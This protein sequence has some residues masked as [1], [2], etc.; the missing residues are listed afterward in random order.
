MKRVIMG[1]ALCVAA[2]ASLAADG[3]T[4]TVVYAVGSELSIIRDRKELKVDEPMGYVVQAGDIVQTGKNTMI[5]LL[6]KPK[7]AV[8]RVSG[9]TTFQFRGSYPTGETSLAVLYGRVRAKV[10]KLAGSERFTMRNEGTVAG[11]RGTDFGMDVVLTKDGSS[12]Q[13]KVSVYSFQGEVSV[14]SAL[15]ASSSVQ[16]SNTVKSGEMAQILVKDDTVS[17]SMGKLSDEVQN[18]WKDNAYASADAA[19]I[20]APPP[21]PAVAAAPAAAA[22]PSAAAGTPV[23]V[24]PP[25]ADA[26]KDEAPKLD[27]G[28]TKKTLAIKNGMLVSSVILVS[29][30][31]GL[32]IYA[33]YRA[34][35]VGADQTTNLMLFGGGI[36][37]ST[38][39]M[40]GLFGLL[41]N[42]NIPAH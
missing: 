38:G 3:G 2:F 29:V 20:V 11:V 37:A 32:E 21:E 6:I 34:G 23:V 8:I 7:K 33:S 18:Y 22:E 17:L 24:A 42:P 40:C 5:E 9:N 14:E 10:E 16:A 39:L 1:L 4:A 30:G 41:L 31:A 19:G 15:S 35:T 36:S 13:T 25:A 12:G 28:L 26:A 27:I